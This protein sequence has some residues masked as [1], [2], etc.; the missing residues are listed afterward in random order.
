MTMTPMTISSEDRSI[1]VSN[2]TVDSDVAAVA[3]TLRPAAINNRRRRV[4]V[5]SFDTELT[6]TTTALTV[7]DNTNKDNNNNNN[8][9]RVRKKTRTNQMRESDSSSLWYT[10]TELKDAHKSVIVAAKSY[11]K[12]HGLLLPSP[13]DDDVQTLE[14]FS[15]RNRKRRTVARDQMHNIVKAVKEFEMK[16]KTNQT[17]MLSKLLQRYSKTTVAK[18]IWIATRTANSVSVSSSY[19]YAAVGAV[20]VFSRTENTKGENNWQQQRRRQFQYHH[21]SPSSRE[22]ISK[23]HQDS[24]S[25]IGQGSNDLSKMLHYHSYCSHFRVASKTSPIINQQAKFLVS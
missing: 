19:H 7:K 4:R 18:A 1:A 5:V 22:V 21:Q 25:I 14:W 9:R 11:Y 24:I 12:Q 6:T 17:E 20:A 23:H 3:M 2:D 13:G 15:S 16:T 10:K 8:N